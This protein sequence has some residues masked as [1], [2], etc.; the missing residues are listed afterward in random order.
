[1]AFLP[2]RE[3][4]APRERELSDDGFVVGL[5]LY[6]VLAAGCLYFLWP[7]LYQADQSYSDPRPWDG[8]HPGSGG[9]R[10]GFS[11]YYPGREGGR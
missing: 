8:S 10:G 3:R 5:L 9:Q 4:S 2:D 6:A 1:M 7:S 11:P